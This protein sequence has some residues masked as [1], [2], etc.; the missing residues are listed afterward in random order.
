[1]IRPAL[2]LALLAT[3][4]AATPLSIP[5]LERM[6]ADLGAAEPSSQIASALAACVLGNGN[7]QATLDQ[8]TAQAWGHAYDPTMRLYDLSAGEGASAYVAVAEDGRFCDVYSPRVDTMVMAGLLQQVLAETPAG[9]ATVTTET[10]CPA[11]RL[12]GGGNATV[13]GGGAE[14]VC[15]SPTDAAVRM[16]F[17]PNP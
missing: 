2:A 6:T 15:N 13:Q 1:M 5:A 16:H 7:V 14:P 11:F 4:A 8:F 12:P 9:V 3:P 10:G 17:A